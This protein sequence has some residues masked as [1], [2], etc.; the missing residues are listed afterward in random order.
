MASGTE[1][2]TQAWLN[3]QCGMLAG[4]TRAT[5]LLSSSKEPLRQSARWPQGAEPSSSMS[6]A[7]ASALQTGRPVVKSREPLEQAPDRSCDVVACPL[8]VNGSLLGVVTLEMTSRAEAQQRAALQVLKWGAAWLEVIMAHRATTL[9]GRLST[10]VD[11]IAATVEPERFR[12]AAEALVAQLANRTQCQ[13]VSL[14]M[15]RGR[16][17]KLIAT[18]GSVQLSAKTTLARRITD[19]MEETIEQDATILYPPP[20]DGPVCVTRAHAGLAQQADDGSVCSLPLTH[21]EGSV[22]ALTL[23]RGRAQCFQPD[24]VTLLET[25]AA[26]VG[27]IMETKRQAQRSL[28][29]RMADATRQVGERLI[30]SGH[31]RFKSVLLFLVVL[32]ATLSVAK[33]THHVAAE[34]SL[35]GN[36]RRMVVAPIEGYVAEAPVRAGDVVRRGQLLSRLDDRDLR[37]ERA[38]W[39]SEQAQLRKSYREALAEHESAEARALRAK[40]DQAEAQIALADEKLARTQVTA[41]LDGLVVSGDLSQSLGAPV[42]RGEVLFEVAPLD[43]YRIMLE[44]DERDIA[45]VQADQSG[46]LALTGLPAERHRFRVRRVSPMSETLEGKNVFRV[47]ARLEKTATSLRPGMRGIAKIDT[48]K[49]HL[50][51]IWSHDIVDWLRL[52]VWSW[53]P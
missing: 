44:V 33:G 35:E 41:P 30:G 32:A 18:S 47:E 42:E 27:P 9:E 51:W 28:P 16:R 15:L 4:V 50:V 52:W 13:R 36:V 38:K 39:A 2:L 31:A 11:I 14:G 17:I 5:V 40:L 8:L 20:A 24:T 48:G 53:W 43:E 3:L 25:V 37:L 7:A 22:G 21:G 26:L 1:E 23:E 10:L 12:G 46:V 19:A 45:A 29:V 49:R 6:T 34:A